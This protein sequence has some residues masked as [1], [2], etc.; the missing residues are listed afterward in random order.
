MG[1]NYRQGGMLTFIK[2]A[3]RNIFRNGRRT[4][5]CVVAVGV[6]VFF[7]AFY[8]GFINGMLNSMNETVQIF[9]IGH[10][11]SVSAQ[12]EAE[13][14]L[15]PVQYPVAEGKSLAALT[16]QIRGIPGVKAVLPRIKAYATLQEAS[17]KHATLWGIRMTEETEVNYFNLTD[18]G[19]GLLEG[20]YPAPLS[21]ECAV[22]LRFA[23]KTGLKI[24]DRIPLKT[25]SAQFSDKLWSPTVTG[26]YRF[27]FTAADHDYIIVDF[28]RLQ[29]LLVLD[30]A[31]QQIIVYAENP[32]M[33]T[34]IASQMK[35]I[36]GSD[37]RI[38]RWQDQLW[39]AMMSGYKPLFTVIFLVFLVVACLLIV[40]TITMIIHERIKEI[41]M[42]GSLG[43]TRREIVMTF[44]FESLF[45]AI[46]GATVGV[47]F[48][49]II[50]GILQNTPIRWTAMMGESAVATMPLANT[51]FVDFSFPRLC[52]NWLMGVVVTSIFTLFP[53]IKSAFVEPV[54]ALRR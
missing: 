26:I 45:L 10:V 50:T 13:S 47:L 3:F 34:R 32:E 9:E 21:N 6:A 19:D 40:N 52:Q 11:Q 49:G 24:G 54:E 51:I 25:V 43:M 18:R 29:R 1:N 17:L 27:D 28:D 31:S 41:G 53:S 37:D 8:S 30:D 4:A 48:G 39:V 36:M 12:Y 46:F 20:R 44:F 2:V 14:E 16:E 33:S 38:I 42:M 7:I 15:M 5:F 23:E 22:G 35:G